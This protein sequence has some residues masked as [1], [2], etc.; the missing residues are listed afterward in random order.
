MH[1]TILLTLATGLAFASAQAPGAPVPTPGFIGKL[2]P[3]KII[4]NNPV[5][6]SYIAQLPDR[7]DTSVRGSVVGTSNTNGTGVNFQVSL[8][9]L[10]DPS[11]GPFSKSNPHPSLLPHKLFS[12]GGGGENKEEKNNDG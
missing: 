3:A 11:L 7:K 1:S 12:K 5:G 8:S 4:Q 2:G 9:G 6:V 10:P